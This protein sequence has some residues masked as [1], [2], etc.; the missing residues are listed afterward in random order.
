MMIIK[1]SII[2]NKTLNKKL[3]DSNDKLYP[4]VR[5]KI[6]AIVN[7]FIKFS[8]IDIPVVDIQLVGSNASFNYSPTS[9]ID[10]HIITNFEQI[11]ASPEIIQALYN[12]KKTQFND[13]FDIKLRGIE[14]ELYVQD[15]NSGIFSNGI[16]SVVDNDWIKFPKPIIDIKQYDL[17][18]ELK[19]WNSRV[20]EVIERNNYDE[21]I[22]L[23]NQIYLIRHNSLAIDGEYGRGNQLFKAIRDQQLLTRLKDAAT[24]ALSRKLSL[25][26]LNTAQLLKQDLS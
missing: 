14:V 26:N 2:V 25:E 7:E 17:S 18:K 9:D 1:E 20:M 24:N 22:E 15:I 8:D 16:Y 3:F 10:I 21:L 13:K 4:Q 23:I 19:K 6:I 5:D 11:T 12:A